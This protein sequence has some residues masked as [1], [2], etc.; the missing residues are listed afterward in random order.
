[1]LCIDDNDFYVQ[2]YSYYYVFVYSFSPYLIDLLNV[3]VVVLLNYKP[4]I[5]AILNNFRT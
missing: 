3:Y 4:A 1:M 5:T 2:M